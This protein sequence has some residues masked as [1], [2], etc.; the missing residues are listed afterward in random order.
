MQ[1]HETLSEIGQTL[2]A[3]LWGRPGVLP[4]HSMQSRS[5]QACLLHQCCHTLD[6]KRMT[7]RHA[8]VIYRCKQSTCQQALPAN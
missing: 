5:D 8:P 6:N 1:H 4:R 7:G 2:H 3:A